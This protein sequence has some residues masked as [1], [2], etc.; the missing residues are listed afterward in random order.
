MT[1]MDVTTVVTSIL[2]AFGNGRDFFNRIH[3][4]KDLKRSGTDKSKRDLRTHGSRKKKRRNTNDAAVPVRSEDMDDLR[5]QASLERGPAEIKKE[6]DTSVQR[7][8]ERFKKGDGMQL[9][10][11]CFLLLLVGSRY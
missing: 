7:L 9:H 11:F 8:G 1:N 3:K 4:K 6:Y 5:I 2:E 10:L